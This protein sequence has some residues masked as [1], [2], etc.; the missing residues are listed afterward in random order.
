P[1]AIDRPGS[2]DLAPPPAAGSPAATATV[3][4]PVNVPPGPTAAS[5]AP[6]EPRPFAVPSPAPSNFA[7]PPPAPTV[8]SPSHDLA[9]GPDSNAPARAPGDQPLPPS[10]P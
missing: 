9:P 8:D 6:T 4:P 3:P 5:P 1:R 10:V 2:I 7:I